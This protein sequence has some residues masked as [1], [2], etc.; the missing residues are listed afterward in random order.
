ME[1]IGRSCLVLVL[2]AAPAAAV[3]WAT[4][5]EAVS[6]SIYQMEETR[7][8]ASPILQGAAVTRHGETVA[9][10]VLSC[11]Y[12][13]EKKLAEEIMGMA[14]KASQLFVLE[15]VESAM[16]HINCRRLII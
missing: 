14:V 4:T 3:T 7:V 16:N 1:T 15:G 10:Y 12:D 5:G 6:D 8:T 13:D 9:D 11:F 2:A